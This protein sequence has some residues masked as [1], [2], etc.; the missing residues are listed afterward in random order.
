VIVVTSTSKKYD[1]KRENFKECPVCSRIIDY[2]RD[3]FYHDTVL[4]KWMCRDH[5]LKEILKVIKL[6]DKELIEFIK[7]SETDG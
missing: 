7:D 5:K 4:N 1:Y 2:Q 3:G 6:K